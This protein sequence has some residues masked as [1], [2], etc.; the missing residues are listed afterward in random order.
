MI[1]GNIVGHI[2]E[3][4][5]HTENNRDNIVDAHYFTYTI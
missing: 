1:Y 4:I 2:I 5:F 3:L